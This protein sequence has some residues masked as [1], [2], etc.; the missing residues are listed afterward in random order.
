MANAYVFPGGVSEVS[1]DSMEWRSLYKNA[2]IEFS[3][4][5]LT[6]IREV[7]EESGLSMVTPKIEASQDEIS[8]WRDA[9]NADAS[10]FYHYCQKY[11]CLPD[12]NSLMPFSHWTTPKQETRRYVTDFY[13]SV[14]ENAPTM[15][16]D[17]KET[18]NSV[19]WSPQ[20]VLSQFEGGQISLAP[21]TWY[22][23]TELFR[24]PKLVDLCQFV[25]SRRIQNWEPTLSQ[26]EQGKTIVALPG[27]IHS[28]IAKGDSHHRIVLE[29]KHSFAYVHSKL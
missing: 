5:K 1:D 17:G 19:W 8:E 20:E 27:D 2:N 9:V 16:H 7:F 22:T 15:S 23:V 6:A 25:K 29:S 24:Y 26:N 13:F 4:S 21:P 10:K 14:V 28:E 11:K 3:C 12:L 18:T